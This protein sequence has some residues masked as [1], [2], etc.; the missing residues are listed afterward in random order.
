MTEQAPP[1]FDDAGIN[2]ADP[3]DRRGLKTEYI[4]LLQHEALRRYVG[5]GEGLALD[6]GCGYGRMTPRIAE[7]GYRV[8][9]ID[10]SLRVLRHAARSAPTVPWIV[11]KLPR[12]PVRERSAQLVLV[13]NVVRP[14]HLMGIRGACEGAAQAVASGGRL[15]VLDNIR[16]GDARYVEERWFV[17]FFQ[18]LGFR[19]VD[20]I[21]IRSSRW[22]MIYLI[23]YGLIPRAWFHRIADWELRRMLRKRRQPR[24]SYHNVL[25]IY[26]RT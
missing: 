5:A 6:V 12:L 9:G 10:P 19:L 20:R 24:L 25:F 2:L 23:R 14:L 13:L 4:S 1:E 17:D 16:A 8:V 18:A 26:E 7:L 3:H 22:P 21:A 15:V 11:G